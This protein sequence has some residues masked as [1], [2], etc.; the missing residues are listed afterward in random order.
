MNSRIETVKCFSVYFKCIPRLKRVS[1]AHAYESLTQV[2]R[3]TP[4]DIQKDYCYP[5]WYEHL[6]TSTPNLPPVI[7]VI[8]SERVIRGGPIGG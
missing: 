2:I 3:A 8:G 7:V 6:V 1:I 5:P 4:P